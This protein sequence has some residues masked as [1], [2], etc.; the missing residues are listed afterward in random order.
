M[1]WN[2]PGGKDPWGNNDRGSGN[3]NRGNQPPDLDEALKQL[4]NKLNGLFGGKKRG[5]N[6]GGNNN[7]NANGSGL[8]GIVTG[9]ILVALLFNSVYTLDEQ[10]RGVLLRLGKYHETTMPGLHFKVPFIDQVTKVNTT[11]VRTLEIRERMLTEDENIV[12]IELNAQYRVSDP[13]SFALRIQQPERSL[14]MAA[15]SA[16][17]HH[18]G[19]ASMDEVLTSGRVQLASDVEVR[20]QEYLNRYQTGMVLTNVNVK[21]ARPPEQVRSAFDDVQVAKLD[22]E[23]MTNEAEAYANAV[24]PEARGQAQRQLEE[25]AAYKQK[26]VS[27]A[28]GEAERFERLYAEYKK[29]PGVTRE[30]LYIDAISEVYSNASKVLVDVEGGNN[31]MY[32]PLDKIVQ[33]LPTTTTNKTLSSSEISKLTDQVVNELRSRQPAASSTPTTIRREGR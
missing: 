18:V 3:K 4:M 33:N 19:S 17:R 6:G 12:E 24:V 13:V 25:A 16:L 21:D 28:Q 26:V 5:G 10:E 32:L 30:R 20:L 22:K 8:F 2:E 31:M 15:Q 1:A 9:I 11:R 29:A 27:R 23:R 7:Y 14:Q